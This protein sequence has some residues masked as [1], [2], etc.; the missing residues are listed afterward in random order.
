MRA[1][2]ARWLHWQSS[3]SPEYD[4]RYGFAGSHSFFHHGS[5]G[6]RARWPHP[7][8]GP[9]CWGKATYSPALIGK[10]HKNVSGYTSKKSIELHRGY[11]SR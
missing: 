7:H 9:I 5:A 10:A 6:A 2:R 8:D 3:R 11:N 1:A 4:S